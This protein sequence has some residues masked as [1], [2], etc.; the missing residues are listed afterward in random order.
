[1]IRYILFDLDCT[2]YSVHLGLGDFFKQKLWEYVSTWL[3]L[4]VE[5][6]KPL[7]RDGL[8]RHGTSLEWLV[9]EKGFTAID[10]YLVYLHPENEADFLSPDPELRRFLEA[11]PCPCSVLTNS[12]YFHAERIIKKLELEGI[13]QHVFSLEANT[14]HKGKPHS[15]AFQ[16]AL[17]VLALAP[18]EV[19][20]I[21]DIPR[22][23]EGYLTIGGK[24]LLL[25]ERGI[26]T[27]YPHERI[28]N[29]QELT[30]F[31]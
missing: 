29:L 31:L 6:C 9:E 15:S 24:G 5:E 4:S 2:L 1:M 30:R 26:Y 14:G 13:F 27:D 12:P 21:D 16:R 19:L 18:E 25:D 3:G 7:L 23:V 10:D 8:T 20:F 22:Y 28:T 11:L 17:D